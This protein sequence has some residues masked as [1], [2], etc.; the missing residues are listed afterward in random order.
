MIINCP[1][2]AALTTLVKPTCAFRFD[3]I[4][5]I[6]FAQRQAG[7][8]QFADDAAFKALA[9]WTPLLVAA[10]ATKV[11]TSPIFSSFVIPQSEPLTAGGNDNST[12]AGIRDYFGEGS[13]T[14]TGVFNNLTPAAMVALDDLTQYSLS[15]AVG[16]SNLTAYFVNKDGVVFYTGARFGVPIY[17]FRL[18]ST[19]SDGLNS[20]NKNAFSFDLRDGWDRALASTKPTFDPLTAI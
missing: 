18:G 5:K 9:T 13:V 4:V 8:S 16:V 19:G 17:N 20:H 1:L 7:A 15:T 6:L 11:V 14:A 12:F 10:D 3:Q 2:P